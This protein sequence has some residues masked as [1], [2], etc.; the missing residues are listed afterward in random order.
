[1][2]NIYYKKG[3]KYQLAEAYTVKIN[4][5]QPA[6]IETDYISLSPEGLLTIKKGYS[7]DGPSGV[8]FDTKNFM[9]GALVHDALYQLCRLSLIDREKYRITADEILRQHCKEDGMSS[10]RAWYVY[11]AVRKFGKKSAS[12]ASIKEILIAPGERDE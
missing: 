9:R 11:Q 2:N 6:D 5:F 10:F 3:Y 1:M 4:L 8:S 12:E 7:N